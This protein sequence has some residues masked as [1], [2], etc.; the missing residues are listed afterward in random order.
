MAVTMVTSTAEVRKVFGTALRFSK[1]MKER[2]KRKKKEGRKEEKEKPLI[3]KDIK[4]ILGL[5]Q[6]Q[7]DALYVIGY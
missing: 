5:K 2:K 6:C 3:K 4:P 1:E 7:M